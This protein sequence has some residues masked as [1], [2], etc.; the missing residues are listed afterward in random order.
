MKQ[1]TSTNQ[2]QT[3]QNTTKINI[4]KSIVPGTKSLKDP[5]SSAFILDRNFKIMAS[6]FSSVESDLKEINQLYNLIMEKVTITRKAFL[7][8]VETTEITNQDENA[9]K[10]EAQMLYLTGNQKFIKTCTV[11]GPV[12]QND[13]TPDAW[14]MFRRLLHIVVSRHKNID[15]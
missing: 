14:N 15:I 6:F 1:N 3:A 8:Q 2:K 5:L 10:L 11:L 9:Q 7:T 13:Q 12:D 4:P